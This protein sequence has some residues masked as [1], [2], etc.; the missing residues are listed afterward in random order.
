MLMHVCLQAPQ[1]TSSQPYVGSSHSVYMTQVQVAACN[2]TRMQKFWGL[3]LEDCQQVCSSLNSFVLPEA[4]SV[5]HLSAQATR[6]QRAAVNAEGVPSPSLL[7]VP[8]HQL[9]SVAY[10]SQK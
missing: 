6:S 9:L 10:S 5:L 4:R 2:T 8:K 1:L 7:K 3:A